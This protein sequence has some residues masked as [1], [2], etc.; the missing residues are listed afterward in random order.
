M[1]RLVAL[2]AVTA[3]TIFSMPAQAAMCG[4]IEKTDC[5]EGCGCEWCGPFNPICEQ[6]KSGCTPIS[7]PTETNPKVCCASAGCGTLGA[8]YEVTRRNSCSV[9]FECPMT[10]CANTNIREMLP[11]GHYVEIHF[12]SGSGDLTVPMIVQKRVP[13][14]RSTVQVVAEKPGDCPPGTDASGCAKKLAELAES[15]GLPAVMVG[16]EREDRPC[17]SGTACNVRI[18]MNNF[19]VYVSVGSNSLPGSGIIDSPPFAE[20]DQ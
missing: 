8:S 3:V 9:G 2:L 7:T 18:F 4:V 1:R 5:G 13:T 10:F 6:C 19:W 15:A 11:R 20:G 17:P 12:W 16:T 14:D